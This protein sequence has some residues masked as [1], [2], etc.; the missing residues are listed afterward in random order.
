L[1]VVGVNWHEASAYARWVGKR[2]PTDAEWVKAAC[3]P[4][5]IRADRST[6]RRYPW[7]NSMDPAAANLWGNGLGNI[8]PVDAYPEGRSVGGLNQMVGNV[9]EWML[10]AFDLATMIAD[11]MDNHDDPMMHTVTGDVVLKNIRG[12]A[13]DSYFEGQATTQFRSGELS[14]SRKHNI[15]F[16]CAVGACDLAANQAAVPQ[17]EA[18]PE[19]EA[20]E[21]QVQESSSID[22]E[23]GVPQ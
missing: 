10:G 23:C 19:P 6:Q 1:P 14:I 8:A 22:L 7:G 5:T 2:L 18:T 3:W 20:A 15:G 9:W 11:S 4:V 13:Y 12:G 17:A 16:R 21:G